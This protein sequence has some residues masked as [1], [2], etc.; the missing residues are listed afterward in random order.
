MFRHEITTFLAPK[1]AMFCTFHRSTAPGALPGGCCCAGALLGGRLRG[2]RSADHGAAAAW[3]SWRLKDPSK[4]G[5]SQEKWGK[6]G[7]KS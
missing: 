3:R 5:K 6:S 7:V 4:I 2:G 1:Q